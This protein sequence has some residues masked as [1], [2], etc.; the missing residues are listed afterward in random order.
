MF[1]MIKKKTPYSHA[2]I[3]KGAEF[4]RSQQTL[5]QI[6]AYLSHLHLL[7]FKIEMKEMHDWREKERE[8]AKTKQIMLNDDVGLFVLT[9]WRHYNIMAELL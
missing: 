6:V 7:L 1:K 8:R 5:S 2:H 9:Q 3:K 4:K